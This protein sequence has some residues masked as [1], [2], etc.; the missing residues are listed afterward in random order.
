ML[1]SRFTICIYT[2]ESPTIGLT[3]LI[4]SIRSK[5]LCFDVYVGSLG[6]LST[7]FYLCIAGNCYVI[8]RLVCNDIDYTTNS[9]TTIKSG[10]G[11]LQDFNTFYVT[12]V[13][14]VQVD[15]VTAVSC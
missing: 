9:I 11:T 1:V 5:L 14:A 15:V 2:C 12:H 7:L 8:Y 10:T 6:E 4:R 3:T 13:N